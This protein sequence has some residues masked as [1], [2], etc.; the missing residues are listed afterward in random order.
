[1]AFPH[2]LSGKGRFGKVML[3][4]ADNIIPHLPSFN[5]V[6]VK[7]GLSSELVVGACDPCI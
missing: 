3:A 7:M 4:T 5:K 1:M 6:A 2:V